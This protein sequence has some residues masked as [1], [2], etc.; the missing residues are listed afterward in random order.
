MSKATEKRLFVEME[1]S[2]LLLARAKKA[3]ATIKAAGDLVYK[4]RKEED[5]EG[6]TSRDYRE[7]YSDELEALLNNRTDK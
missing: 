5:F 2:E 1:L 7:N 4:W 6:W 3:E